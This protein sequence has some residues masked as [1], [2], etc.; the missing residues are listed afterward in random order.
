METASTFEMS[1]NFNQITRRYNTGDSHLHFVIT[2]CSCRW[3]LRFLLYY[4]PFLSSNEPGSSVSIVSDYGLEDQGLI[5]DRSREFSSNLS[6]QT[7]QFPIQWVP[8]ILSHGGIARP[9][10][11][12][13]PLSPSSAEVK[14]DKKLYLLSPQAPAWRVAGPLYL[15]RFTLRPQAVS[16]NCSS[17][18]RNFVA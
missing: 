14:K 7:T 4:L 8:G 10:H 16:R 3:M 18:E 17:S 11:N 2:F 15:F 5:L 1:V 9:G 13:D 6:A 12:A